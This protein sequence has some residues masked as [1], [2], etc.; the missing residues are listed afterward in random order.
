MK[1]IL[2]IAA[3]AEAATGIAFLIIPSLVGHWLLG[4]DLAGVA[5]ALARAFGIALIALAL[6]CWPGSP[7]LAMLTYSVGITS[8]LTYAGLEGCL[9]GVLLWPAVGLHVV[10]TVLL[11]LQRIKGT[12]H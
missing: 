11:A 5:V 4:A 9:N 2:L 8:Y 6:A 7:L 1:H 10:L 3:I 12:Q